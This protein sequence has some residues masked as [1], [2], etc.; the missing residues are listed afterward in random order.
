MNQQMRQATAQV[1]PYMSRTGHAV[2]GVFVPVAALIGAIF[3]VSFVLA[4]FWLISQ[5]TVFGLA[6]PG[7]MPVWVGIICLIV[8]YTLVSV[9]LR[10]IRYGGAYGAARH[11]GWSALHT[12]MWIGFTVVLF[13]AAYNFLPGVREMIDQIS[14]AANLTVENLSTTLN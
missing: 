14:W 4:V 9:P 12:V 7:D 13:W 5:Q 6:L 1:G 10:A 8:L 3:F 11:P 2:A